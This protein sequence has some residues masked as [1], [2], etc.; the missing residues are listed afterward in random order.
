MAVM[1][2]CLLIRRGLIRGMRRSRGRVLM[3]L[4]AFLIAGN[5]YANSTH[6]DFSQ[7]CA[8]V[9]ADGICDS[10][11]TLLSSNVDFYPLSGN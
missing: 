2:A 1:L 8:D 5:F 10:S 6:N 9:D 11:R 3:F 7:T 4:A